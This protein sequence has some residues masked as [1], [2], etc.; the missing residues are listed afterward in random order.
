MSKQTDDF[1]A[2]LVASSAEDERLRDLRRRDTELARV[3][4]ERDQ[5]LAKLKQ[6]EADL[7][8]AEARQSVLD[9]FGDKPTLKAYKP[10]SAKRGGQATAVIA[11]TDWHCEERI[12]AS[13]VNGLNEHNLELAAKKIKYS[14]EKSIRLLDSARR[15]SKIDDLVL[16]LGGDFITG[17]I[18]EELEENNYLSPTEACLFVQEHICTGIDFL[19]THAD[20]KHITIPTNFGNHGRTTKRMR[21]STGYKNSYEWLLYHQISRH[22]RNEP[23]VTWKIENGYHNWLEIQGKQVR[24]HHGDGMNYWGG[25]GGLTIPVLK[26]I[27]QWNKAKKADLDIF[28]HWHTMVYHRQFISS[29]CLVGYNAYALQIKAD[30]AEPSQTFAV[31]DRDRPGAVT[32][33]E[34]YCTEGK[35]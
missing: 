3:K 14:F 8:A 29:G 12:D 34:I 9:A 23:R 5:A 6:A 35:A 26:A 21:A 4:A 31:I 30:F 25:V 2:E 27:A 1:D 18:H 17:Y 20:A 32:V 11:M 15:M 28:G 16:W 33:Q 10:S 13:T 22:Y 7:A 19:L 24:F